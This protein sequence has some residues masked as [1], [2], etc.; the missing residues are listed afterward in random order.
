MLQAMKGFEYKAKGTEE[1]IDFNPL[2]LVTLRGSEEERR[3]RGG[4]EE[5]RRGRGG[6][7]EGP[8]SVCSFAF[9]C[10]DAGGRS[11]GLEGRRAGAQRGE[12]TW[13]S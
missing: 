9:L 7:V 12:K 10:F 8:A 4:D 1:G 3:K 2:D 11:A 5:E 6:G 13:S